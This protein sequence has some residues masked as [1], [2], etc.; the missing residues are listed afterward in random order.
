MDTR[1]YSKQQRGLLSSLV[2]YKHERDTKSYSWHQRDQFPLTP[3]NF[4]FPPLFPLTPAAPLSSAVGSESAVS[5][6]KLTGSPSIDA[7]VS[8]FP[9]ANCFKL[10]LPSS[11]PAPLSCSVGSELDVSAFSDTGSPSWEGFS[12]FFEV[13]SCLRVLLSWLV[14]SCECFGRRVFL[15]VEG[16]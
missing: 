9:S 1:A 14:I 4:D 10:F 7:L 5:A 3:H 12:A 6:F 11:P 8:S 2:R 16:T 15:G 13:A